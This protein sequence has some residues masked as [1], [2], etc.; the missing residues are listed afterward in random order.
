MANSPIVP[1]VT[2]PVTRRWR[3]NRM[4]GARVWCM[5]SNGEAKKWQEWLNCVMKNSV[6]NVGWEAS[7]VWWGMSISQRNRKV[8]R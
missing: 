6:V 3:P 1:C 4:G 8:F 5:S 2:L 7:T